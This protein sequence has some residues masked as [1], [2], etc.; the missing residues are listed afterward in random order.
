MVVTH[1]STYTNG[2]HVAPG[3]RG[4]SGREARRGERL[5]LR[6]RPRGQAHGH[7]AE[8]KGLQPVPVRRQREALGLWGDAIGMRTVLFQPG[9]EYQRSEWETPDHTIHSLKELLE[10][11]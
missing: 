5:E 11:M 10:L 7:P 4:D 1:F 9:Q 2:K 3:P 6:L 8:R